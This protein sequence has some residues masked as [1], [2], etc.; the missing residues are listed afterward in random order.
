MTF[1]P[2]E[3]DDEPTLDADDVFLLDGRRKAGLS[4][5]RRAPFTAANTGAAYTATRTALS[6]DFLLTVTANTTITLAGGGV[7]NQ[8]SIWNI[9]LKQDATGGHSIMV[10]G[11]EWIGGT[12]T[13]TTLAGKSNHCTFSQHGTTGAIYGRLLGQ[14]T[15]AITPPEE[16]A[17][18]SVLYGAAPT[19]VMLAITE[20]VTLDIDAV[21]HGLEISGAGM[22]IFDPDASR[23]LEVDQQRPVC[24]MDGGHLEMVPASAAVVH[25]LRFIDVDETLFTAGGGMDHEGNPGLCVEN[26]T[27]NLRGAVK[28]GWTRATGA[29]SAA[30]T[31]CTVA[32]ATG[33]AIGDEIVI[34]PTEA[35]SVA[36]H[37]THFDR[38]TLTDVAGNVLTF[39][40]TTYAHP[41]NTVPSTSEVVGAEV[42]NLTRNVIVGGE[43]ATKRAQIMFM[44]DCT[45][46][47]LEYFEGRF[48]GPRQVIPTTAFTNGVLGRYGLHFHLMAEGSRDIHV[49]GV[50]MHDIGYRAFVPHGSHGMT[51]TDCVAWDVFS[52]GYWWDVPTTVDES[53]DLLYDHCFAGRVKFSRANPEGVHN[54][55]FYLAAGQNM[56]IR[57]CCVAG[58]EGYIDTSGY[59]WPEVL[60][61]NPHNVWIFEDNDAHNI[62]YHGIFIWQNDGN[63]H[64]VVRFRGWNC[65]LDGIKFGAYFNAYQIEDIE[66]WGNDTS[67]MGLNIQSRDAGR[68]VEIYG[69][70]HIGELRIRHHTSTIATA[71]RPVKFTNVNIDTVLVS[72]LDGTANPG[73]EDFVNCGLAPGDVTLTYMDVDSVIRIQTG[74]EAWQITTTDTVT[75]I[76]DEIALF[77]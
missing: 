21:V 13:F 18:W 12:P 62:K 66:V 29:I 48:L 9:T 70:G 60:N 57:N 75:P 49:T 72:E 40:A 43:D 19:D 24:V 52:E 63:H 55:G 64:D 23:L 32:D 68:L 37:E 16:T 5:V 41:T 17:L 47:T 58:I 25:E 74:A 20:P 22:L 69:G 28:T 38:R 36:D 44:E 50:V 51:F 35:S 14:S 77:A 1:F 6:K 42:L 61:S 76:V 54:S 53:N 7:S 4:A 2:A 10:A 56:T 11:V 67:D 39:A 26:G 33:W 34:T 59:H 71:E 27:V 15:P 8:V 73:F 30:A 31:T 45:G 65:F 46:S 3:F